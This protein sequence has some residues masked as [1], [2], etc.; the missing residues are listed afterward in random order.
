MIYFLKLTKTTG[1]YSI[2]Q[3]MDHEQVLLLMINSV[4]QI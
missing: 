4:D 1:K 2:S 3:D